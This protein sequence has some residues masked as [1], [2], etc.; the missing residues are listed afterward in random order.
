M[1]AALWEDIASFYQADLHNLCGPYD[2][3]YGMD[4]ESYVSV[5]GVWMRTVLDAQNAPL[6]KI[7]E[8]TDHVADVWF[9]P[10]LAILGT[11]I[12]KDAFGK[13]KRVRR[14]TPGK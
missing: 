1:E 2:R 10:H 6:P 4:M 11:Q 12:P 7:T 8:S 5:V 9:A 13:M 14:R 3:S